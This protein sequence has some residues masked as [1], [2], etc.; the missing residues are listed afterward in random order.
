MG[1]PSSS[2]EKML[3]CNPK[4]QDQPQ[5]GRLQMLGRFQVVVLFV[6]LV[7]G[8]GRGG[9]EKER[10]RL[11]WLRGENEIAWFHLQPGAL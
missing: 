11:A 7:A 5:K 6:F 1:A 10:E 4:A 8:W 2:E 9:C 3:H